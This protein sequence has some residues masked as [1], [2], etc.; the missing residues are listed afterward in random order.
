MG[1]V[2]TSTP[3][4]IAVVMTSFDPGGTE[5]QMIELIRRLDPARWAVHVACFHAR[6]GW[7]ERVASAAASVTEFKVTSFKRP[8]TL[9]HMWAFARWCRA[10][11]IAI[12]HTSD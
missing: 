9:R 5:R 3:V 10:K 12:V 4:P 11:G 7:F 2:H 6:G 1:C 8:G